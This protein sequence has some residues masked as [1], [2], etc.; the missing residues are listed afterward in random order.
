MHKA[1]Y[2]MVGRLWFDLIH[3]VQCILPRILSL[4]GLVLLCLGFLGFFLSSVFSSW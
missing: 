1:S 4:S 3:V 2:G